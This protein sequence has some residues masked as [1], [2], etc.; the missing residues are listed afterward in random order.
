MIV[1]DLRPPLSDAD[2][3][4]LNNISVTQSVNL[5]TIET[6]AAGVDAATTAATAATTAA[7]SATAAANA[8]TT[9]ATAATTAATA[10]TNAATTATATAS[11]ANTTATVAQTTANT[12]NTA[13]AAATTASTSATNAATTATATAAAATTAATAASSSASVARLAI[14]ADGDASS[15]D[16]TGAADSRVALQTFLSAR[17]GNIVTL[18]PGTIRMDFGAST[19]NLL[20]FPANTIVRGGGKGTVL[21]ITN[22]ASSHSPVRLASGLTLEDITIQWDSAAIPATGLGSVCFGLNAS[23]ITLR[24]CK[25]IGPGETQSAVIPGVQ[26]LTMWGCDGVLMEDCEVKWSLGNAFGFEARG[27]NDMTMVRCNVHDNGADGIKVLGD[28]DFGLPERFR[29]TDCNFDA[30]GQVVMQGQTVGGVI[31]SDPGNFARTNGARYR[32]N[33]AGTGDYTLNTSTATG[34]SFVLGMT[35]AGTVMIKVQSGQN[36]SVNGATPV[37]NGT[38]S[39]PTGSRYVLRCDSRTDGWD[40]YEWTNGEGA[41]VAGVGM[42]FTNCSFN[43]NQGGGAQIKPADITVAWSSATAYAVGSYVR[44][45]GKHYVC[46][47]ASTN[48]TPASS[49]TFWRPS[50]TNASADIRFVNCEANDSW[51]LTNGFAIVNPIGGTQVMTPIRGV[52][53]HACRAV[54]NGGSGFAFT[55]QSIYNV[56]MIGCIARSNG[57]SGATIQKWCRDVRLVGCD[58][59]GNGTAGSGWNIILDAAKGVRITDCALSGVDSTESLL[60]S[61]STIDAATAMCY[62]LFINKTDG[63]TYTLTDCVITGL[64][65][66]NHLSGHDVRFYSSGAPNAAAYDATISSSRLALGANSLGVLTFAANRNA[67]ISLNAV[68]FT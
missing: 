36:I 55:S 44:D 32:L 14:G 34:T 7:T 67:S 18:P 53:Y 65:T 52:S 4:K 60:Y 51:G 61:D 21:K 23:N 19:G 49:P 46:I 2:K 29:A 31:T 8:A 37:T 12:A 1:I 45:G 22:P 47:Q 6:Q 13:A 20:S 10:A 63:A 26:S 28:G 57:G 54:R 16:M 48:N 9:A 56:T 68:T 15:L 39:F 11:A 35:G 25:F 58:F 62:G 41:D 33:Y 43:R 24:R 59:A 3:A 30:N 40:V 17:A 64:T 27:C 66:H 38:T 5:D 42:E 50:N